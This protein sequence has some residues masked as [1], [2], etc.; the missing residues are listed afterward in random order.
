MPGVKAAPLTAEGYE[1]LG[2]APC[3]ERIKSRAPGGR[4]P[5]RWARTSA[6]R[7]TCSRIAGPYGIYRH[8]RRLQDVFLIF[9]ASTMLQ[10]V[11]AKR[12]RRL[13][14]DDRSSRRLTRN[15][16]YTQVCGTSPL[17]AL[18]PITPLCPARAVY[19]TTGTAC[20]TVANYGCV[21]NL[22]SFIQYS[23]P[24]ISN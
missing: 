3:S 2:I 6:S 22:C 5:R 15:K 7:G 19:P 16:T 1:L 9:P 23:K 14:Q 20:A 12:F 11:V 18:S 13:R 10:P 24:Q 21:R 8:G 17:G 4:Q